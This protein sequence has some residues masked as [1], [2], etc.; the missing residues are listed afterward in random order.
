MTKAYVAKRI[1]VQYVTKMI[2]LR[3][4]NNDK[5]AIYHSKGESLIC[6]N[7]YISEIYRNN[8]KPAICDDKD[9]C[10]ICYSNISAINPNND[11]YVICYSNY[12]FATFLHKDTCPTGCNNIFT[13]Y[14]K[15]KCAIC[16]TKDK[17]A[18][19]HAKDKCAI[20]YNKDISA[21]YR[22]NDICNM[23]QQC[24]CDLSQ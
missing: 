2:F 11:K 1:N 16:Y 24:L 20:C 14:R 5:C 22:N 8:D 21:I 18:I 23:L 3:Y 9:K 7:K 4:R 15:D 17:C 10:A 13:I 19:N 12:I 6:Y